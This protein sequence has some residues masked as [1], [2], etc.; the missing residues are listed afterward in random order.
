M[1]QLT[2]F[3]FRKILDCHIPVTSRITVIFRN[4]FQ[5]K[6][7]RLN[8]FSRVKLLVVTSFQE[9]FR[10]YL[11]TKCLIGQFPFFIFRCRQ[12]NEQ[13]ME[14]FSC[15][16]CFQLCSKLSSIKRKITKTSS[17]C[18]LDQSCSSSFQIPAISNS[19]SAVKCI[20]TS[21]RSIASSSLG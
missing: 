16:F 9:R 8:Y 6:A 11:S 20:S 10:S 2:E 7:F 17:G 4:V 5:E 14:I 1:I 15:S 19:S 21:R 13:E 12:A 3:I 18:G